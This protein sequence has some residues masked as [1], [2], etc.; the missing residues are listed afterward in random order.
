MNDH[1]KLKQFIDR[2][3]DKIGQ[4]VYFDRNRH[5]LLKFDFTNANHHL[6]SA[7]ISSTHLFSEWIFR[8]LKEN[9]YGIGGYFENRTLYNDLELFKIGQ[10]PRSL[11]LGVDIWGDAGTTVF[12]ALEGTVHSFQDNNN[13]GDYGPTI[14]LEHDLE[15]LKLY[16]LYGH[17]S[18]ESLLGLHEGMVIE[19]GEKL[20]E[21]GAFD[22]NG[23]WPPHLH[24][25]LMF[26]MQGHKGD[27]PGACL[28]AEKE[29]WQQNIPDPNL[30]LQFPSTA[31]IN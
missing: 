29:A 13:V 24:F 21:F 16:S 4:V 5:R 14:I 17:L 9:K 6:A 15:G 31:I 18:I 30:I 3:P 28:L 12:A 20:G 10:Q 1:E 22:E 7:T 27:Y 23:N 2:Y 11:H 26:D 8:K 25:Q 19:K